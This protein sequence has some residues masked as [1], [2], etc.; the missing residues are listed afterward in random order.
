M[1][2]EHKEHFKKQRTLTG[3]LAILL[4]IACVVTGILVYRGMDRMQSW[5]EDSAYE[6][7]M[8]DTPSTPFLIYYKDYGPFREENDAR[9]PVNAAARFL[10]ASMRY[11]AYVA[12]GDEE[13][14]ARQQAIIDEKREKIPAEAFENMRKY[15]VNW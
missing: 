2:R 14:A 10:G 3:I 12:E 6:V 9:A 5:S 15:G 1:A 11:H 8:R 4:M 13:N 7:Y